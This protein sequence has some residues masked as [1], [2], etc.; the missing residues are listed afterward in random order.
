[1][2]HADRIQCGAFFCVATHR[3]QNCK[4]QKKLS[5]VDKIRQKQKAVLFN[6]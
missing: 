1:M 6:C 3:V 4:N 5:K 2:L